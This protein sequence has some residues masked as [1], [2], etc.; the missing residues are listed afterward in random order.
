MSILFVDG[1]KYVLW[2]PNNEENEF[3]PVV[4]EMFEGD[5]WREFFV[6]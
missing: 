3:H 2:T 4:R 1:V 5:I 6:L